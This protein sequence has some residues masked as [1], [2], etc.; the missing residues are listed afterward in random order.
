MLS[1]LT[2]SVMR[3]GDS[4]FASSTSRVGKHRAPAIGRD[5][6]LVEIAFGV[7]GD[8]PDQF[9]GLFRDDDRCI[10]HQL[11]SPARAPPRHARG[12]IDRRIG[13]LP[14][15]QPQRDGGIFVVG[16]IGTQVKRPLPSS[17]RGFLFGHDLIRKPVPTFRDHAPTVPSAS[18]RCGGCACRRPRSRRCRAAGIRRSRPRPAAAPERRA[19]SDTAP[20]RSRAPT[21]TPSST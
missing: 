2:S 14:G 19:K 8:E 16:A 12:E 10:R 6:E 1:V 21:T 13:L 20:P 18:A 4:R 3:S 17:L 7:D 9:S 5:H 11:I 15:L